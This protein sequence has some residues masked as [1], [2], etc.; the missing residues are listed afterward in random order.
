M[1]VSRAIVPQRAI[2]HFAP[3]LPP[4]WW[5]SQIEGVQHLDWGYVRPGRWA[6]VHVVFWH[7]NGARVEM[8][9]CDFPDLVW[10]R[11]ILV[12]SEATPSSVR[13]TLVENEAVSGLD[14]GW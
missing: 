7:Q 10:L 12:R 9:F 2:E 8:T 4:G 5:L 3:A 11:E 14:H 13:V 1:A 6:E